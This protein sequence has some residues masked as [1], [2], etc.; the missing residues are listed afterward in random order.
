MY[1][2]YHHSSIY[3]CKTNC[4]KLCNLKQ[5][6]FFSS[7]HIRSLAWYCCVLCSEYHEG[8]IMMQV[9]L[10]LLLDALRKKKSASKLILAICTVQFFAVMGLVPVSFL[11]VTQWA[12]SASRDCP[13]GLTSSDLHQCVKSFPMLWS[14]TYCLCP[15]DQI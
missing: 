2:Y 7:L 15:L 5:H 1:F 12:H 6:P 13:C 10:S 14:F 11:A 9:R 8:T 3:Y 4:N